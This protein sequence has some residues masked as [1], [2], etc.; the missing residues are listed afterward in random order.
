MSDIFDHTNADIRSWIECPVCK[1]VPRRGY[2]YQCYNGHVTCS[3][4]HQRLK[5][6]HN[7]CPECNEPYRRDKDNR[8]LMAE[9]LR[10]HLVRNGYVLIIYD[11]GPNHLVQ[12]VLLA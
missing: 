9:K 3:T 8:C 7:R 6:E 10:N 5:Q 1:I 4:C 2:I 11:I 12:T